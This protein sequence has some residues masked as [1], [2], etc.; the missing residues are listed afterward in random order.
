MCAPDVLQALLNE[1]AAGLR[2]IFGDKLDSVIL[3]G[4]YA[5][6]DYD[7]ESDVDIM[8]KLFL[9][10]EE[11]RAFRPRVSELA[12]EIGLKYD[13]LISVKLQDKAMFDRYLQVLPFYRNVN[14]D[15]VTIYA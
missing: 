6:G 8:A 5:R 1:T 15:G 2:D 13:I 10:A 7:D 9:T 12:S 11:I 14:T 3:Y 4:S